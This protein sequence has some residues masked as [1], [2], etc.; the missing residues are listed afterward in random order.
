MRDV[1]PLC[2]FQDTFMEHQLCVGNLREVH[3]PQIPCWAS[4]ILSP[5]MKTEAEEGEITSPQ[6]HRIFFKWL[7]RKCPQLFPDFTHMS[8]SLTGQLEI[9]G[10]TGHEALSSVWVLRLCVDGPGLCLCFSGGTLPG[11]VVLGT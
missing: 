2:G 10:G 5:D 9:M 1:L 3:H 8:L 4:Y 11:C 6:S 7:I